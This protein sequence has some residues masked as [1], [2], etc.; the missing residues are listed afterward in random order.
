MGGISFD[1]LNRFVCKLNTR[2]AALTCMR[3]EVGFGRN[4]VLLEALM[5]FTKYFC[6]KTESN[7]DNKAP[8]CANYICK[9]WD[10]K[11]A[12]SLCSSML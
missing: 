5:T 8:D 10:L 12:G 9:T 11:Q 2:V 3:S 7:S 6:I 4:L 1:F